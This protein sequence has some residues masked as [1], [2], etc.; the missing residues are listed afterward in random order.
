MKKLITFFCFIIIL[1]PYKSIAQCTIDVNNEG[2]EYEVTIE[3]DVTDIVY[4]Q[5][6]STCN[7]NLEV[8]SYV[9]TTIIAEPSWSNWNG[10]LYNLQGVFDCAGAS[11]TSSFDLPLGGGYLV[12]QSAT[13]SFQNTVCED[14]TFDCPISVTLGGPGE[15][16]TTVD[17]GTFIQTTV[18]I[19]LEN[20]NFN[21]TERSSIELNWKTASEVNFSHFEIQSSKDLQKWSNIGKVEGFNSIDGAEYSYELSSSTDQRYVRL[22]MQDLD[23]SV[24]YSVS[25]ILPKTDNGNITVFPNPVTERL[26]LSG[27]TSDEIIIINNIGQ[28]FNLSTSGENSIDVSSL[29]SGYYTIK[30]SNNREITPMRFMKI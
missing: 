17:C 15:S 9:E 4:T 7:V 14:V 16:G 28:Q 29:D 18:P 3:I 23:G 22:K 10:V 24:E 20:F 19:T 21:E 8:T 27:I 25:L 12:D 30:S 6:G 5:A 26:F 2:F 1:N 11:G 13:F